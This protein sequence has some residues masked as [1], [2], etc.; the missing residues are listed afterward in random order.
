M[1]L[2]ADFCKHTLNFKFDAGTS[3]GVLKTKDS[4]FIKL[5][6]EK[7]PHLFG[8]GEAAP[9][10]GLSPD[11]RDDFEERLIRYIDT[12]NRSE[13]DTQSITDRILENEFSSF[14]SITFALETAIND[15][16]FGGI[17]K[18]FNTSFFSD[19][20]TIKINGLI[21]MGNEE[22]MTRQIKQ[23]LE[24]GFETIK[25]KIGAI[26][27]DT[28]MRLLRDVRKKFSEHQLTLRVDANGAFSPYEAREVLH[29]LAKSKIHSIE[30]PI[31]AGNWEEMARLCK[32]AFTPVALDE[33]LIGISDS[34]KKYLL[35]TIKP[36]FLI[37]KPTLLGGFKQTDEWI[38]LCKSMQ[39]GWWMTS[40]LESNIG[41]NSICQYTHSQNVTLP[42]GLGTGQLYHN[43]INSPLVVENGKI[44]YNP[45]EQWDLSLLNFRNQ[46]N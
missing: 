36:Q 28:E 6:N 44:R 46:S 32:D 12:I 25:M 5:W 26:D 15:L 20:E 4:W 8:L 18:I 42:Q 14:P 38:S 40:A 1:P 43:N 7:T 33:E 10:E 16:I 41:L 17:R 34:Q 31:K 30:Q 21:W 24:S 35:D 37:F 13:F 22:F 39:I 27:F 3:R 45:N 2:Q 29:E 11:D 9:L 23:K 19:Q